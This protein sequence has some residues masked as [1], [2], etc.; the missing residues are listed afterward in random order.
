MNLL[1]TNKE[2]ANVDKLNFWEKLITGL[3]NTP[4]NQRC[5]N[6]VGTKTVDTIEFIKRV[7]IETAYDDAAISTISE[8]L[9]KTI[10]PL[11]KKL[12]NLYEETADKHYSASSAEYRNRKKLD[13]IR[14]KCVSWKDGDIYLGVVLFPI[15]L[16]TD[17]LETAF[18]LPPAQIQAMDTNSGVNR[19]TAIKWRTVLTCLLIH[20]G[21]GE[22]SNPSSVLTSNVPKKK[23]LKAEK[24]KTTRE[25]FEEEDEDDTGIFKYEDATILETESMTMPKREAK[26]KVIAAIETS[27]CEVDRPAEYLTSSERRAEE[28]TWRERDREYEKEERARDREH[29]ERMWRVMSQSSSA[30]PPVAR[31]CTSC[32]HA[33]VPP[34]CML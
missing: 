1:T 3:I 5:Y 19:R 9:A 30:M 4:I 18:R 12:A 33:L 31:F 21:F 27:I 8:Y 22:L 2:K 7:K 17:I 20:L 26:R 15:V 16:K 32:G 14:T 28:N 29:R 25:I 24:K 6:S 11:S 34:P 13:F 10:L 23:I